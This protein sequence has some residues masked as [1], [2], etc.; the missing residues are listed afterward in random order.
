MPISSSK[1]IEPVFDQVDFLGSFN[2]KQAL[3][4]Q[5]L[6]RRKSFT[7]T[8]VFNDIAEYLAA[9]SSAL[10]ANLSGSETLTMVSDSA[11]DTSN[12]TGT[13]TVKVAYIDT[14]YDLQESAAITLSGLTPV[15]CN[16]NAL[17]VLWMEAATGGTAEVSVGNIS[18]KADGTTYEM[19]TAG[20]NKSLSARFMV[21]RNYCAF[22]SDFDGSAISSAQNM[23]L[24]AT[25]ATYSRDYVARYLFQKNM[26]IP[27][28]TDRK[29]DISRLYYPPLSRIKVS[30]I[31]GATVNARADCGFNIRLIKL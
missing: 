26:Y 5:V 6:G 17:E 24:R 21:P 16:F 14:N 20:G 3:H 12:G 30:T 23:R 31:S 29:A 13:R 15:N 7:S 19:I 2:G 25:V 11:N 22:I 28:N 10:F 4:F 18:L 8:S 1:I 9:N 27:A